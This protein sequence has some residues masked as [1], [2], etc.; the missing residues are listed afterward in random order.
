MKNILLII[1]TL[2]A[3]LQVF[4]QE[5]NNLE[6]NKVYGFVQKRAE[7]KEGFQ[8]FYVNFVNEF[9]IDELPKNDKE[10]IFK[11]K[12]VVEKDGSFSDIQILDDKN[13]VGK[14]A[15]RVLNKMPKW[16][17]AQH[18]GKIVR[19]VYTIPIKVGGKKMK[20][21]KT[22]N[23]KFNDKLIDKIVL[24]K[25]I[26]TDEFKFKCNCSFYKESKNSRIN[27]TAKS[28][29]LNDYQGMYSI[30]IQNNPEKKHIPNFDELLT[31]E[32]LVGD[33]KYINLDGIKV[34]QISNEDSYRKSYNVIIMFM[35]GDNLIDIQINTEDKSLTEFLVNDFIKTFKLKI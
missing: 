18:N 16:N 8:D 6:E 33:K 20:N 29:E 3:G 30:I 4:A 19:S 2:F 27:Q 13:G 34:F 5:E 17:P 24:D 11:L 1:L 9:K 10:L 31:S 32:N 22:V 7:P 28:Y 25:T 23:K 15:I 26:E 12:F 35:K 21:N 14:E